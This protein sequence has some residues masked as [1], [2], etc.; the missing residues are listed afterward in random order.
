MWDTKVKLSRRHLM[1][2]TAGGL[3][4]PSTSFGA[5]A[6]GE[7]KFLFVF[8][9]GGWDPSFVFAPLFDNPNVNCE[10]TATTR[11][12]NGLRFV[13]SPNRPSVSL[14]F[15]SWAQD[16][17]IING[18]DHSTVAHDRGKRLLMTGLPQGPDDWGAL[19]AANT[20]QSL[21][22]PHLVVS[23]PTYVTYHPDSIVRIGKNGELSDLLFGTTSQSTEQEQTTAD[24]RTEDL[25]SDYL[26]A[27]SI[28]H[29]Q[30]NADPHAQLFAMNLGQ[31]QTQLEDLIAQS[32]NINFRVEE[33]EY[34][35]ACNETFM[36]SA[37]IAM[38]C[39]EAGLSRCA[40]VEDQ[41]FCRM[42]W[43]SHGDITEQSW[44]YELLFEGLNQLMETLSTR[45]SP[46]GNR[47]S[48]E[49]TVVVCSELGR[50]PKLNVMGGKHHWPVT[51]AM[52]IGGVTGGRSIGGYNDQVLSTPI[53]LRTGE[54]D[55]AGTKLTPAHLGST[56]LAMGDIDPSPYSTAEP[57]LGVIS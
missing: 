18:I 30:A 8:C 56:L 28:Q 46:S 11:E 39:F 13:D 32:S 44:H 31:T 38:D 15:E 51:S 27:R 23:G 20:T 36:G 4:L 9:D 5:P 49:V 2:L 45:Y 53:D 12:I 55:D 43:D 1:K 25:I 57:I 14:F 42:R 24:L 3:L 54:Q 52:I 40:I 19:I 6:N 37:T 33:G 22:A 29:Q 16:C 26:K 41:G 21:T 50:H 34:G 17:L 48:D 47:L 7:R 10:S 35:Y